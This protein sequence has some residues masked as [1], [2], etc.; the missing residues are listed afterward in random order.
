MDTSSSPILNI[1][2]L[3]VAV[4]ELWAFW[5]LFVKAGKPGWG[6]IIPIYNLYLI[7]KIAG[8]PGWW[9]LLFLVPIV[10]IVIA[11]IV[12]LDIA[13]SFGRGTGFGIGLIFLSGIFVPIL[14]FG[15]SRYLGPA[16]APL[17]P[18]AA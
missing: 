9:L 2:Y 5:K 1:I 15:D 7:I 12:W 11:V 14:A 3:V 16:A 17:T 10:N 6:A 13:R 8:R 4:F 18:A